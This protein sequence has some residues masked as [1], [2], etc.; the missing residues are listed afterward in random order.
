MKFPCERARGFTL[1]E[2]MISSALMVLILASA[3][4]SLRSALQSQRTVRERE[5]V[6]Q[7]A[8]VAMKLIT[9]DLRN[10]CPLAPDQDFLG[11]KRTLGDAEADNVDF[12]TRNYTPKGA[13]EADRCEVSYFAS[14]NRKTRELILWRRRDA[15]R[16]AE[17]FDGGRREEIARGLVSFRLEYYDGYEW[18]DEWG[19]I[20]GKQKARSQAAAAVRYNAEGLPEAVRVTMVFSARPAQPTNS[21]NDAEGS[22]ANASEPPMTFQTIVRVLQ[23]GTAEPDPGAAVNG[24]GGGNSPTGG[25]SPQP[26]ATNPTNPGGPS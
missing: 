14:R 10:A 21:D 22:I 2:L 6:L 1:I 11:M 25:G 3:Y 4:L 7:N 19:D 16:D 15:T 17:P 23:G 12:G 24:G 26:G 20:N 18:Y 9:D 5:E 8:R 13:G